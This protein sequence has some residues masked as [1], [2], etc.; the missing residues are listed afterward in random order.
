MSNI[1]NIFNPYL[2]ETSTLLLALAVMIV[3]NHFI[4]HSGLWISILL[5][6]VFM[7]TYFILFPIINF[8]LHYMVKIYRLLKNGVKNKLQ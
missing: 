7:G 6:V 4:Y 1:R 2:I 3:G 8:V 5:S